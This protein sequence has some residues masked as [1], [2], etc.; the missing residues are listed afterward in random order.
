MKKKILIG[1]SII[2]ILLTGCG[3]TKKEE[4]K[5]NEK[6]NENIVNNEPT[7]ENPVNITNE[8][9]VKDQEVEA[10]KFTQTEI[11]YDGNMTTLTSHVTNT[12]DQVVNLTTVM[13]HITYI[14]EFNNEKVLNMEVYFGETLQPGETRQAKSTVDVDLRKSSNIV[15]EIIG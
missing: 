6:D 15:Y 1:M 9:M 12:S 13:S 7:S 10:L 8:E 3:C 2:S 14:D 4:E 5:N 11:V